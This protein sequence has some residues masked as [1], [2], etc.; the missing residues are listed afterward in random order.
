MGAIKPW[1]NWYHCM[2]N[3]YGT[4]LPGDERGFRTRHHREHVEG[5]Y[6]FP[7]PPGYYDALLARSKALL[8][9]DPVLLPA[10]VRPLVCRLFVQALRHYHV[11][12]VVVSVS[13]M[14]FHALARFVPVGVD[15]YEHLANIGIR[16][17]HARRTPRPGG[18]GLS[19]YDHDP[20]PR[21]ILGLVR[22]YTTHELKRLGHF[23]DRTGGLWA[24]RPK[25]E[26][27]QD[28]GHEIACTK[29]IEKHQQQGAAVL[30]PGDLD[31]SHESRR[32]PARRP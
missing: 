24:E 26:P 6:K 23:A 21:R 7:P 11:E 3:T 4:W 22:S 17:T 16:L 28:R 31:R 8:K 9:R 27:I 10:A 18:R 14:H 29:Y 30:S 15:P 19:A 20:V 2:G 5:D 25:C 1:R 32:A 12:V 13:T